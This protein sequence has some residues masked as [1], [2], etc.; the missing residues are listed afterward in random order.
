VAW[1]EVQPYNDYLRGASAF[2]LPE[3]KGTEVSRDVFMRPHHPQGVSLR[4]MR[5]GD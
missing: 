5:T 4:M 2:P 3:L 1:V